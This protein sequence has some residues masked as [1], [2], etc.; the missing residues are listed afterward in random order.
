MRLQLLPLSILLKSLPNAVHGELLS[1]LFNHLLQGQYVVDQLHE[2]EG[3]RLAI[4]ISDTRSEIIF[5]IRGGRLL[6][7]PSK[8]WDARIKGRL[9]EFWLLATRSE[10]PDTLFFARRLDIEGDTATGLHI[11]N[12]LDSLDFDWRIHVQAAVGPR[13]APFIQQAV[14][15]L[16]LEQRIQQR[17][18]RPF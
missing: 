3:K 17:L 18:A 9:E 6:R 1:R 8:E 4:N 2:L 15:R 16:Q 10:D 5:A 11:K 12:L 14:E 13:L 7:A